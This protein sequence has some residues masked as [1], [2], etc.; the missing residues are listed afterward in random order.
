LALGPG[1]VLAELIDDVTIVLPPATPEQVRSALGGS[2]LERLLG[3]DHDLDALC[4]LV[5]RLSRLAADGL[6]GVRELDL[7]PVL[8]HREGLSIVDGLITTDPAEEP[9]DPPE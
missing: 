4:A 8:V 6:P 3:A 9:P 7:N 1:G 5:A 2:R